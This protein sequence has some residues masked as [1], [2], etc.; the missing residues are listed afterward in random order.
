MHRIYKIP[1]LSVKAGIFIT[2]KKI[3][4]RHVLSIGKIIFSPTHKISLSLFISVVFFFSGISEFQNLILFFISH[5]LFTWNNYK[6]TLVGK[7]KNIHACHT[8]AFCLTAV[9]H[10]ASHCHH[11]KNLN[12]KTPVSIVQRPVVDGQAKTQCVTFRSSSTKVN[13]PNKRRTTTRSPAQPRSCR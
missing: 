10:K 5:L 9:P 4:Y 1:K 13:P 7:R 3:F 11:T 2:D 6:M 8:K 12:C